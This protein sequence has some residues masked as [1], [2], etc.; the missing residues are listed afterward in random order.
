MLD[1]KNINSN[2]EI[3]KNEDEKVENEDIESNLDAMKDQFEKDREDDE[4]SKYKD[5][6]EKKVEELE[7]LN[8]RF[9]RLQA[10]FANYKRRAEKERE[11]IYVYATEELMKQLLSVIDNFERALSSNEVNKDDGFYKGIEMVYTQFMDILKKNGLEEIKALGEKFDP[12]LHHGI[13]QEESNEHEEDTVI[14]VYQKGY[15][16]KDKVIRPSMVK[17]SK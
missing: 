6:Y 14:D 5:L 3:E 15:K 17:I 13:A 12:N 2:E 1:E 9:V 4:T 16:L 11:S 8:N 7:D 10:D